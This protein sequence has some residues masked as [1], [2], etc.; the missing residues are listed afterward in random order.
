[1]CPV[2]T[3]VL[4]KLILFRMRPAIVPILRKNQ[5]GFRP[6]RGTVAHILAIRRILEGIRDKKLSATLVFVDFSNAFD[7]IDRDNMFENCTLGDVIWRPRAGSTYNELCK[8]AE[9]GHW[10]RVCC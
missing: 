8:T 5:N 10:T 7:S 2:I 4:N 9:E 1:M 3:K 6:E